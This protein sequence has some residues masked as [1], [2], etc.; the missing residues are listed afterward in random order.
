LTH[1]RNDL[2]C[3]VFFPEMYSS[4]TTRM[5][6]LTWITNTAFVP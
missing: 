6:S 1:T 3:A 5:P 4:S 2:T